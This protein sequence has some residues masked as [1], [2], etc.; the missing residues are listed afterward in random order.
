MDDVLGKA[1]SIFLA[2]VIL[3]ML[4]LG[5]LS[6]RQKVVS[7]MYVLSESVRLVDGVCNTG[8]LSEQMLRQFYQRLHAQNLILE[9][10]LVHEAREYVE[11]GDGYQQVSTY[12]DEEDIRKKLEV[13]SKYEVARN[14][15]FQVVI[16]GEGGFCMFP[17]CRDKTINVRYGGAVRYEAY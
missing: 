15:F 12:F 17:W 11:T 2:A 13:Q 3:C 8:F 5:Y 16:C 4:P 10:R 9:V 1:V 6:E 7:Q 14:D